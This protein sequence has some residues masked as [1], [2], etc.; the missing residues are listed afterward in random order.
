[1]VASS[2][3]NRT[4]QSPDPSPSSSKSTTLAFPAGLEIG[5]GINLAKGSQR[6]PST[7]LS[8]FFSSYSKDLD[9]GALS[10]R[11]KN[12][13]FESTYQWMDTRLDDFGRE[14]TGSLFRGCGSSPNCSC[15][16]RRHVAVLPTSSRPSNS[17]VTCQGC[18][19]WNHRFSISMHS[20][21]MMSS[22]LLRAAPLSQ[23]ATGRTE[24]LC[25]TVGTTISL[26]CSST[27]A[28]AILYL[29][30]LIGRR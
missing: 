15:A 1:M 16:T 6:Y 14:S 19:F 27:I 18:I 29:N 9:L 20:I 4:G 11:I 23:E 5:V 17:R 12:E 25:P 10:Y 22:H 24:G 3:S 7:T 2:G 30:H 21:V 26:H 13:D 28:D 8:R